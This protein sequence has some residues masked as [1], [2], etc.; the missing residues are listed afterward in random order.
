MN[1]T[2][3]EIVEII[4]DIADIS[5]EEIETESSLIDTLNLNS[6]EILAIVSRIEK[7]FSIKLSEQ[8]LLSIATVDD[9]VKLVESKKS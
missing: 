7:K 3:N 9:I 2:Y 1:E 6:L 5:K 4:I 8:E